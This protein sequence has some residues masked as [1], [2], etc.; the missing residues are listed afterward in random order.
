MTQ[1]GTPVVPAIVLRRTYKAPR[2]RVSFLKLPAAPGW[3]LTTRNWAAS[4]RRSVTQEAGRPSWT[5]FRRYYNAVGI[6]R[7]GR[8]TRRHSLLRTH[9]AAIAARKSVPDFVGA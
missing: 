5:R 3:W 2:D 9:R 4:S 6:D 1:T 8:D 7:G